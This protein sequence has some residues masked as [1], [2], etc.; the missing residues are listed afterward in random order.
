[1]IIHIIVTAHFKL[2][3]LAVNVP[4]RSRQSTAEVISI[5]SSSWFPLAIGP[6]SS[7]KQRASNPGFV[8]WERPC[9]ITA[10]L[11]WLISLITGTVGGLSGQVESSKYHHL[12]LWIRFNG[13]VLLIN[14]AGPLFSQI[15]IK[16]HVR[17]E[18]NNGL[19]L[20]FSVSL[21]LCTSLTE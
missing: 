7:V 2:R 8:W 11:I 4:W 12:S 1:M 15:C 9:L 21:A 19:G 5:H 14:G 17:R 16:M 13:A 3:R 10:P 20:L 6:T 18:V